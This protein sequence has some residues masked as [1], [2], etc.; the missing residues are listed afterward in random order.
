MVDTPG[1][2]GA[3]AG[4]APRLGMSPDQFLNLSLHPAY[5]GLMPAEHAG[6][7]TAYLIAA[8]A[9]E[10]HGEMVTGYA[11]LERAGIIS[12]DESPDVSTQLVGPVG[13]GGAQG[14]RQKPSLVGKASGPGLLDPPPLSQS[15]AL[16]QRLG[17]TIAETEAEFNR[18]PVFVR[19]M[20]RSGFKSRSGQSLQEWARTAQRLAEQI[21]RIQDGEPNARAA[22]LDEL[23]RLWERLDKLAEYYQGVP[24]ETARFTRDPQVLRQA[25]Q[26]TQE[27]LALIQALQSDLEGLHADRAAGR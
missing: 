8:L 18:L 24:A 20:A 6:V 15:L 22:L 11:V 9:D 23:P 1:L 12:P 7:A 16:A 25:E 2:R 10:Y 26:L 13:G 3:A 17:G 4:L 14:F 19:P 5:E 21:Q 27:R